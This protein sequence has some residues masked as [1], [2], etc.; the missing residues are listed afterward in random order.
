MLG[1]LDSAS[2]VLG[3]ATGGEGLGGTPETSSAS[4]T[5]TQTSSSGSM[6]TVFGGGGGI[7][8]LLLLA[9]LVWREL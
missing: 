7:L 9:W 6:V 5:V 3:A 1:L 4:A 8:V 2:S